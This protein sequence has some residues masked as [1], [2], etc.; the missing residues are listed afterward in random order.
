ML[1]LIKAI[2]NNSTAKFGVKFIHQ[3]DLNQLYDVSLFRMLSQHPKFSYFQENGISLLSYAIIL[4][5]DSISS[6]L[7]R[8]GSK[9]VSNLSDNIRKSNQISVN[10]LEL[11]THTSTWIAKYYLWLKLSSNESNMC[12]NCSILSQTLKLW[13]CQH[14][15]C[16]SCFWNDFLECHNHQQDLMCQICSQTLCMDQNNSFGINIIDPIRSFNEDIELST[17]KEESFLKWLLLP[18]IFDPDTVDKRLKF[19]A[20]PYSQ[21]AQ[22][23]IGSNRAQRTIELFK[24]VETFNPIRLQA[25]MKNGVHL[26]AV[27]EYGQTVLFYACWK[28]D[29]PMVELLLQY[30]ADLT[31]TDNIGISAI[32]AARLNG[33]LELETYLKLANNQIITIITPNFQNNEIATHNDIQICELISKEIDFAGAGS[34]TIDNSFSNEH[35]DYLRD[36]ACNVLPIAPAEKISCSD[37]AYYCDITSQT[38]QAITNAIRQIYSINTA[39]AVN[40]NMRFLIYRNTGGILAAHVDLNRSFDIIDKQNITMK[41]KI[42]TNHTFILYL[43]DCDSGGCTSLLHS[44]KVHQMNEEQLLN[45]IICSVKPLNGRLLIFPH[46]CP[47]LGQEVINVPKLLLR[48]EVYI[49]DTI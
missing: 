33:F 11:V 49:A 29:K 39:I 47:H 13:P 28:G 38:C 27:N 7:L 45:N 31:I 1:L 19:E 9:I 34:Y 4:N 40:P 22:L 41:K 30:G 44:V 21:M 12:N 32:D 23:Y 5:R 3:Y 15:I 2:E 25:L 6:S 48:G 26:D 20:K 35:L 17:M 18:E 16:D 24:S 42:T 43:S 36:L 10:L 14:E 37:R 46:L 8:A